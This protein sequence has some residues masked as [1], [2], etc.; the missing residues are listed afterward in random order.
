MKEE[1]NKLKK[2]NDKGIFGENSFIRKFM[3][4]AMKCR[5]GTILNK[6]RKGRLTLKTLIELQKIFYLFQPSVRKKTLI[7]FQLLLLWSNPKIT[8]PITKFLSIFQLASSLQPET[9]MFEAQSLLD[10]RL[11]PNNYTILVVLIMAGFLIPLIYILA[12]LQDLSK[13]EI[14]DKRAKRMKRLVLYRLTMSETFFIPIFEIFVSVLDCADYGGKVG[15]MSR[16][17]RSLVC[18]YSHD[19]SLGNILWSSLG[20]FTLLNHLIL[21]CLVARSF[22]LNPLIQSKENNP[23]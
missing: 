5:P 13:I 20:V 14:N 7:L 6:T 16:A 19:G 23:V 4:M 12:T 17:E 3:K 11:S 18:S 15:L 8:I 1:T 21:A 9:N 10:F 22:D 2:L